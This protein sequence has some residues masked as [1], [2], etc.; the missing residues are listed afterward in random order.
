MKYALDNFKR[1]QGVFS[2]FF[3]IYYPLK[4]RTSTHSNAIYIMIECLLSLIP[5]LPLEPCKLEISWNEAPP[6]HYLHFFPSGNGKLSMLDSIFS[7][8][9]P[10]NKSIISKFKS[11]KFDFLLQVVMASKY[12][13]N[14]HF[15]FQICLKITL[16]LK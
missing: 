1:T 6:H 8:L 4:K 15:P 5:F 12:L 14:P 7:R 10:P 11:S 3:P 9:V 2:N 16:A 13:L